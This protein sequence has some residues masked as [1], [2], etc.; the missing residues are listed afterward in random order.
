MSLSE[1]FVHDVT[2]TAAVTLIVAA[3]VAVSC[4]VL[5]RI[6]GAQLE[7]RRRMQARN[8]RWEAFRKQLDET[9]PLR[10]GRGGDR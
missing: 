10:T 9:V 7:R 4:W 3:A 8:C 2:G 5:V 1:Q 6:V